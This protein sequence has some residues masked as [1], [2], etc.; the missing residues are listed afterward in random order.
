M[1]TFG[2]FRT[3]TNDNNHLPWAIHSQPNCRADTTCGPIHERT[4][5][6]PRLS[7]ERRLLDQQYKGNA[8]IEINN[9]HNENNSTLI[10][11]SITLV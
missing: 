3:Y 2:Q 11:Q 4:S 1:H 5:G 8:A 10:G 7:F 9:T 6:R